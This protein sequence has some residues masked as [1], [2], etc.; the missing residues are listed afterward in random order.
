MGIFDFLKNRKNRQT[1]SQKTQNDYPNE[2]GFTQS[3]SFAY[4]DSSSISPDERPFYQPDNYYTYY[5]YPGTDMAVRVITF[6]ERKTLSYPSSRGLYVAEIMLLE[7]CNKNEYPKPASGYPGF[8]WFKYGIRDVGHALESLEKRG[9]IQWTSLAGILN[10]YKVDDLRSILSK[11]QLPTSGKKAELIDRVIKEIPESKLSFLNYTPK[12]E[13]TP[14][15]KEE[16]EQNGYVPYMHNHRHATT[17]DARFGETFTV[18]DI[19]KLFPTG[20]TSNWR[21]VVGAIEY[22]RF[23]VNMAGSMQEE[24]NPK[25]KSNF[26]GK[27]EEMRNYLASQQTIIAKGIRTSG[28]GFDEESQGLDLKKIGKDKEALVQFYISIGKGFDAP[29]LYQEA[30]VLLR[31][32]K[33][34]EEELS[35]IETGLKNVKKS[36]P[37][38]KELNDRKKK[39]VELLNK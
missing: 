10:S 15:G 12:Y 9:F 18:W 36:N 37:H 3:S 38:W 8:W 6:D 26:D 24:V 23:G 28:D 11:E 7:Y 30:A 2:N 13:L 34:Y 17:E 14:I 22:R 20:N 27:R 25:P 32:Y 4:A 19:N 29:A 1:A 31:K 16:L 21:Q 5:S 35:V 33:M 39:V